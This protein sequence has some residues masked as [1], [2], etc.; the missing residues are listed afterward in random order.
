MSIE[1]ISGKD[2]YD[3]FIAKVTSVKKSLWIGTADIKALHVKSGNLSEPFLGMLARL[4]KRG[5][6]IR[7][8]H[9]K[10]PGPAFRED[11]DRYPIHRYCG[12]QSQIWQASQANP[13]RFAEQ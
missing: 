7:L 2:H 10:E 6:E 1:F 5:A 9:A 12:T 13:L 8:I 3:K 11:F 4:L